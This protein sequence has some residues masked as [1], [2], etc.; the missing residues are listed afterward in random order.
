MITQCRCN[1]WCYSCVFLLNGTDFSLFG[2]NNA[3]NLYST[4][5]LSFAVVKR[6]WRMSFRRTVTSSAGLSAQ[7]NSISQCASLGK[8]RHSSVFLSHHIMGTHLLQ[9]VL[10]VHES[11]Y[12]KICNHS[13]ALRLHVEIQQN[14]L[15]CVSIWLNPY[16][17]RNRIYS[18]VL[19]LRASV[20]SNE[21]K[22]ICAYYF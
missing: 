19:L 11:P 2:S 14:I 20:F 13:R 12:E 16:L 5:S 21:T 10:V 4:F 15:C 8:L 7:L 3:T 1:H 17:K 9:V 6:A 18:G 22:I